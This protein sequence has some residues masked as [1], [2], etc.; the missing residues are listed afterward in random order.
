MTMF[1]RVIAMPDPIR[2]VRTMTDA[3]L[4]ALID[5]LGELD[6]ANEFH[7]RIFAAAMTEAV[8]RWKSGLLSLLDEEDGHESRVTGH[9]DLTVKGGIF[10]KP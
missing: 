1:H 5:E 8:Q 4:V 10:T 9:E 2:A 6:H 7:A 3:G